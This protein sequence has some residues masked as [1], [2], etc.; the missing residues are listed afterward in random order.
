MPAPNDE[1]QPM[2]SKLP[3]PKQLAYLSALAERTGQ[4]FR[5]DTDMPS[6]IDEPAPEPGS[7]AG[8]LSGASSNAA[9][10]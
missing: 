8:T 3:T 1:R 7:D 5:H 2:P 4:T 10:P 9:D 6:L